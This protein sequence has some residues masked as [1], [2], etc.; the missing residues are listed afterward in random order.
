MKRALEAWPEIGFIDD[1]DGCLFTATIHRKAVIDMGDDKD[2]VLYASEN[3][4]ICRSTPGALEWLATKV[5]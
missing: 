5:K 4:E 1:R 3:R 2:A